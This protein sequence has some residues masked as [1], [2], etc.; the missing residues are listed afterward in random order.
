MMDLSH[1]SLTVLK[2]ANVTN[3]TSITREVVHINSAVDPHRNSIDSPAT[4]NT[5][6]DN[7]LLMMKPTLRKQ[8]VYYTTAANVTNLETMTRSSF[9]KFVRDCELDT[10]ST[11]PLAEA[12]LV[13]IFARACGTSKLMT[14]RQWITASQLILQRAFPEQVNS[15]AYVLAR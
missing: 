10:M 8:F 4:P 6:D 14:F 5:I 1:S 3:S 9:I 12:D 11:P 13:N 15:R 2:P 7:D